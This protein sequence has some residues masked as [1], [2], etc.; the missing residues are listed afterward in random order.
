MTFVPLFVSFVAMPGLCC[1]LLV[2]HQIHSFSAVLNQGRPHRYP[3][4]PGSQRSHSEE[5]TRVHVTA[6]PG[7]RAG[8]P[9]SVLQLIMRFTFV[10]LPVAIYWQ[11]DRLVTG[12]VR[13]LLMSMCAQVSHFVLR[14]VHSVE[15]YTLRRWSCKPTQQCFL[16][17]ERALCWRSGRCLVGDAFSV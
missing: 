14:P 5:G 8:T 1:F 4:M 11:L 7:R 3:D 16:M 15:P 17:L 2:T 10:W 9:G 6:W 12:W 13:G